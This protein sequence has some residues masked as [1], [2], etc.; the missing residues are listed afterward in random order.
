MPE[1]AIV[2]ITLLCITINIIRLGTNIINALAA[3]TPCV[4]DDVDAEEKVVI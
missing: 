2:S 3:V 4:I 1:C